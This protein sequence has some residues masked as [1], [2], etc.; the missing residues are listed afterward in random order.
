MKT[1]SLYVT[2]DDEMYD[3]KSGFETY[4]EANVYREECQRSWINHADYV[5]LITRDSAGNFVKETN[6]TKATKEERIKLLEEAG[7]PLK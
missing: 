4:Y 7:I 2:R 6:L 3:T 5:F 1:S